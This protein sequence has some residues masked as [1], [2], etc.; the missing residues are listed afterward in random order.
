MKRFL[1]LILALILIF[2]VPAAGFAQEEHGSVSFSIMEDTEFG[3]VIIDASQDE[4][5][6]L[7]ADFGDSIDVRFSNGY[8]LEDIPYFNGYYGRFNHP[9][10]VNYPGAAIYVALCSGDSMWELSGC[11]AGDSITLTVRE[12]GKY[13]D[14]QNAMASVY[15]DDRDAFDSDETFANF[16]PMVG[17]NLAENM[18]FRGASP[19][20][21]LHRRADTADNL[22]MENGIAYILN[23]SDKKEKFENY[24]TG[25]DFSSD[26]TA[27][28]YENGNISLLGLGASY[29][30]DAYRESLADGLRDM[31]HH[32]GPY[33]IHCTE[34]KD[35]TGFVCLLL[36][37]LAGASY[38]EIEQDY[39]KTYDNY[40]G[41]TQKSDGAKYDALKELRLYDMLWWLAGLPDGTDL[42]GMSFKEAAENYLFSA[43]MTAD[44]VTALEKIL[45]E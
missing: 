9:A 43:G 15:V 6:R 40:Y 8:V 34:G 18:F 17:G 30:S 13:L 44:E 41:I 1:I 36:E 14:R 29:R 10:V 28:L 33:Y 35:R 45:T 25:E 31:M 21:N 24:L 22:V 37:A 3:G 27:K 7:G 2:A 12:K 26:Y 5:A 23:L 11:A 4:F 39:M 20:D 16:R 32:E 42:A 38:E 19:V